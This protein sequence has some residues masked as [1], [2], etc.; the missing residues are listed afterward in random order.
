MAAILTYDPNSTPVAGRILAYVPAADTLQFV[1]GGDATRPKI[2]ADGTTYLINPVLPVG[3][4]AATHR[5]DVGVVR[6]Y[7]QAEL[8]SISAARAAA[9]AA[10]ALAYIAETKDAAK[11]LADTS[12]TDI[13]RVIRAFMELTLQE[14]NTL[15]TKASLTNYTATQFLN[16]LKAK[17]DAQ[18]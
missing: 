17:I 15:R 12:T 10:A 1:V 8:D 13:G 16:A 14:I 18:S 3:T 9:D 11:V 5:V 2:N 6:A 7:T 4:T